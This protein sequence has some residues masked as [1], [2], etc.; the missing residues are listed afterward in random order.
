[1]TA[2]APTLDPAATVISTV[3][4][5]AIRY[6]MVFLACAEDRRRDRHGHGGQGA[7]SLVSSA[8]VTLRRLLLGLVMRRA[9][10]TQFR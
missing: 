9:W 5:A 1:V 3:G 4:I 8:I 6:P 7:Q 10:R 2:N